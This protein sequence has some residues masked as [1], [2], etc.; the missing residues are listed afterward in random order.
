VTAD[1]ERWAEALAI[2]RQYG[3]MA[4]MWIAE[5]I[6]ALAMAGDLAGVARFRAVAAKYEQ[7]LAGRGQA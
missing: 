3:E 5:R 1:Q 4:P 2:E 7:L 6:G